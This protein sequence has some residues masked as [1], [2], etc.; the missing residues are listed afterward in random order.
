MLRCLTLDL[1]R[2]LADLVERLARP[3]ATIRDTRRILGIG[4]PPGPRPR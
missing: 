1:L 2:A 4:Q 3:P